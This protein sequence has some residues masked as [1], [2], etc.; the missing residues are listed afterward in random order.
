MKNY[1]INLY[2]TMNNFLKLLD[3]LFENSL[4]NGCKSSNFSNVDTMGKK[5]KRI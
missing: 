2:P 5:S 1:Y 3:V 4:K